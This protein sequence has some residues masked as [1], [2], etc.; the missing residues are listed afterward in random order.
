[1][2]LITIISS[3][4]DMLSIPNVTI[5]SLIEAFPHEL[6]YLLHHIPI[7]DRIAVRGMLI[8]TIILVRVLSS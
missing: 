1:M 4:F 8:A 5:W 3:A 6:G 2:C 7:C